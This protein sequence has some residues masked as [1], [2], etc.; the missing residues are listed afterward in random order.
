V[1]ATIVSILFV[2]LST[3]L[4]TARNLDYDRIYRQAEKYTVV[5]DLIVEVSFG[6]QTTEAEGRSIGSIATP[7]G[8][9]LFD[10][11]PLNSDDPFSVLAGMGVSTEPKSI[12][13]TTLDGE[14]YAAEFV[15]VDR[16]TRI[17]FCRIVSDEKR[18]FPHVT[19]QKRDDFKIGEWL[20][21]YMLLPEFVSP[22][23]S[24][25]IGMVSAIIEEPEPFVLTMGFSELEMISVIYDSSARPVGVLGNL[26]NPAASGFDGSGLMESF[27]QMDEFVPLLGIIDADKINRLIKNPPTRGKINRGWIGIFL[28]ALTPDIAEFWGIDSEGGIIVNDVVPNSPADSAGIATGDVLVELSGNKI[29]I[30]KEESIPVFQKKIAEM[31]AGAD[32]DLTV[33]RRTDNTIDTLNIV[34]TLAAAPRAPA[35]APD[36]HDENFELKIRDMVFADYNMHNLD[37]D[38]FSGVVVKEVETGGWASVGG[39]APGDII[40]KIGEQPCANVEDAEKALK[41]VA[42]EKKEEVV[43]FVWR[44]NKTLFVNIKTDW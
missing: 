41:K 39:L 12:E 34:V 17:G 19:F 4:T 31:G 14:S 9:V 27:S 38:D 43:F 25:D 3:T 36:Y 40:Q 30:D 44:D 18:N 24:A 35:E 1:K 5:V 8:L 32:V 11:T 33:L 37:R 23:I 15:G 26:S 20:G 42:K 6:V 10:G 2:L 13:V 21:I 29:A 28:Q 7:D 22:V 16:F